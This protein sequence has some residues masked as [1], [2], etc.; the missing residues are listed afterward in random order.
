MGEREFSQKKEGKSAFGRRCVTPG[1]GDATQA[2]A[3]CAG[4]GF[5]GVGVR[6]WRSLA[7]AQHGRLLLPAGTWTP[8]PPSRA[9][10]LQGPKPGLTLSW[11]G[12]P[13]SVPAAHI[14]GD[15]CARRWRPSGS[16]SAGAERG[17]PPRPQRSPG[18]ACVQ[19]PRLPPGSAGPWESKNDGWA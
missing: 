7:A 12:H 15:I 6:G 8:G 4:E 14:R 3:S 9:R 17:V 13:W 10:W 16:C 19:Q 1:P 18:K 11:G 5:T 2:V